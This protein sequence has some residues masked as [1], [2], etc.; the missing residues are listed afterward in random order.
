MLTMLFLLFC[1][2]GAMSLVNS[3][4]IDTTGMLTNYNK[5]I[6]YNS[7]LVNKV[8][9]RDNVAYH[10]W[11][12]IP[13]LSPIKIRN[14]KHISSDYGYR[15]HPIL[16][17][18]AMHRG[19]DFSAKP[20]TTV[21][22]TAEGIVTKVKYSRRGYG[23]EIII[24]HGNGYS[25]RYAHLDDIYVKEG[26]RVHTQTYIG[27]VG[28]TGLST[29]PHLHYEVLY[30]KRPIDPMFFT[31]DSH[32]ERSRSKY[33][34]ALIALESQQDVDKNLT[35]GMYHKFAANTQVFSSSKI[36]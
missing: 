12:S 2:N 8:E 13:V 20:G 24:T 28:N 18:W 22:S 36:N 9:V 11:D 34:N 16:L 15:N 6:V 35:L 31:Y 25:T 17:K 10:H 1:L 7:V 5:M 33:F 21:Y 23:H 30:N 27:T 19:V 32:R 3:N 29:G 26:Q 14:I 4:E